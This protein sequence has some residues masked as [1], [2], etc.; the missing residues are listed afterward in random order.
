MDSSLTIR[1]TN[2]SFHGR[3]HRKCGFSSLSGNDEN[4]LLADCTDD[5]K[6][7][8]SKCHL[9]RSSLTEYQVILARAGIFRWTEDILETMSICSTHRDNFGKYWRSPTTCRYPIHKSRLRAV[10]QGSN[11]RVVNLEMSTQIMDLYGVNI[12]IG[13]RTYDVKFPV[14]MLPH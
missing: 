9:S 12:P 10:K 11:A 7:H 8:L 5:M 1:F 3:D 14:L 13:S 6:N 4:R 2:C